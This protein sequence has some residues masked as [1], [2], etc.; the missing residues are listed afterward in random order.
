MCLKHRK[1][2][3]DSSL[4]YLVLATR[5][6]MS[7]EVAETAPTLSGRVAGEVPLQPA[8]NIKLADKCIP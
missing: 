2:L 3:L 8:H 4:R 1:P 7:M 6:Q 5:S